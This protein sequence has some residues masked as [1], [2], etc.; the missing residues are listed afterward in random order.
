VHL[1]CKVFLAR[2]GAERCLAAKH[3]AAGAPGRVAGPA[4][5]EG[6]HGYNQNQDGLD[7]A[8]IK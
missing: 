8:E 2:P 3:L 7:P 6:R 5:R 4:G 1:T